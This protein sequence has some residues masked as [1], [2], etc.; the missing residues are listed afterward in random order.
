[1]EGRLYNRPVMIDF[2]SELVQAE[3]TTRTGELAAAQVISNELALSAVEARID[4]W[5]QARANIRARIRS[6]GRKPALLFACHLDVVGPGDAPWKHP[7]FSG[8]QSDGRVYGRGA[9][10]MK[11]G[12]AA[13]VAAIR[14]IVDSGTSLLGDVVFAATAGEETDS[15]G[16]N[17]FL[18]G[19]S[20]LPEFAG[21][22]IPEPTDFEIVTA[23]RGMFWIEIIT[24]GK[25]A[26]GSA[27]HLGIN[28]ISS[29]RLLLDALE[30]YRPR[31]EPHK[32]LGGCSMSI[33]TI[34]GGK[35]TNVVPD[36]CTMGIDFR[37]LPGQSHADIV[38]DLR[39]IF[40]K[41]K[42]A[43]PRFEAEISIVRQVG[44][45]ETDS[46]CAFVRYFCAAVGIDE[47][48][49]VGF[50]TD[51]PHFAQLGAPVVIFG[52]GKPENCHKPDEYIEIADVE[53]AAKYYKDIILKFLT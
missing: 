11:G 15:S 9:T 53:R 19:R 26:H 45:L 31:A 16:A 20:E 40:S 37:T 35:A 33:N 51:G 52:P 36:R 30:D 44:P 18:A 24:K 50:T 14:Q 42:S 48:K 6:Q 3:T 49:A 38:R 13:V 47:T 22:V 29:A 23:H 4:A 21:V 32:L 1:M 41:L 5:D 39:E 27:P 2:L 17:R 46:G 8:L 12:I 10:D 34:A 7:P 25:A 28:A 43:D